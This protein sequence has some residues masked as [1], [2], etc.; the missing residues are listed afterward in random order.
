MNHF[1][2][3]LM[4]EWLRDF[5]R[6]WGFIYYFCFT[7]FLFHCSILIIIELMH[8]STNLV[9]FFKTKFLLYDCL[10]GSISP[11][12]YVCIFCRYPFVKKSQSRSVI[13]EKLWNL[14]LYK[15][16]ARKMLVK[17]TIGQLQ[18]R[19]WI[20]ETPFTN[21]FWLLKNS[22][23]NRFK[24]PLFFKM[25]CFLFFLTNYTNSFSYI[26]K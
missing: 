26:L 11:T 9:L 15:K 3:T 20:R 22:P 25:F 4:G 8:A 10:L 17:S 21:S 24:L 16:C 2:L 7:M 23:W 13:R 14:L 1:L 6:N 19:I 18:S 5:V 12:F